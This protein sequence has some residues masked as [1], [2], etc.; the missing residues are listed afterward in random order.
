[1]VNMFSF[2]PLNH[3]KAKKKEHISSHDSQFCFTASV[4]SGGSSARKQPFSLLKHSF[5]FLIGSIPIYTR[6]TSA[7]TH[8]TLLEIDTL[9][10]PYS[11]ALVRDRPVQLTNQLTNQSLWVTQAFWIIRQK[12]TSVILLQEVFALSCKEAKSALCTDGP[13]CVW[14]LTQHSHMIPMKDYN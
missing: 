6:M 10:C 5:Q 2:K 8:I 11:C 1:M 14:D 4:S 9:L 13:S 3:A 12:M 7:H